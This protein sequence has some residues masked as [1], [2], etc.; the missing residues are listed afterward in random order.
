MYSTYMI[1]R[2]LIANEIT[3]N[4]ER[5][6]DFIQQE[7]REDYVRRVRTD[8]EWGGECEINA[9]C[10]ALGKR[11][12][13]HSLDKQSAYG[14]EASDEIID[15]AFLR[16]CHYELIVNDD[17]TE[18][19]QHEVVS[20]A[21]RNSFSEEEEI[22]RTTAESEQVFLFIAFVISFEIFFCFDF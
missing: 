14:A 20:Q 6:R 19:Q 2:R 8:R 4:F 11:V 10:N 3:F 7:E 12:R 17:S 16:N 9:F 21:T 1:I 5:Y 13:V 18:G 15:L 22:M